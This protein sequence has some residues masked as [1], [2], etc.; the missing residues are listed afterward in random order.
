[1]RLEHTRTQGF[2]NSPRGITWW[3]VKHNKKQ[4]CIKQETN[5]S[6]INGVYEFKVKTTLLGDEVVKVEFLSNV[7]KVTCS[8]CDFVD[9]TLA[10]Q[11]ASFIEYE[12]KGRK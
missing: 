1:M 5:S 12:V 11:V 2:D 7:A 4:Y 6:A 10:V 3:T 8:G 9:V